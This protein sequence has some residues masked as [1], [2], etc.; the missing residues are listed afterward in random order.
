VGDAKRVVDSA[1]RIKADFIA[2]PPDGREN[3][4]QSYVD[5]G[6][7]EVAAVLSERSGNKIYRVVVY[8]LRPAQSS[9]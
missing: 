4:F 7:L 3:D 1:R 8:R 5:A 9:G 6:G 2:V